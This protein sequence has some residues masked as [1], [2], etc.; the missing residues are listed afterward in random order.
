MEQSSRAAARRRPAAAENHPVRCVS[1]RHRGDDHRQSRRAEP[2]SIAQ[3]QRSGNPVAGAIAPKSSDDAG[4]E[5]LVVPPVA[6]ENATAELGGAV[7]AKAIIRTSP[8]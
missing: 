3:A 6:V 2:R 1:R 5:K 8:L 4:R 7:G